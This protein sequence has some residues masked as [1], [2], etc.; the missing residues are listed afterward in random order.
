MGAVNITHSFDSIMPELIVLDDNKFLLVR[1]EENGSEFWWPPGA[2][3]IN[4]A[5]CNLNEYQPSQWISDTLAEQLDVHASSIE[6]LRVEFIAPDHRPVLVYKVEVKGSPKANE[7][8][9]FIEADYFER[10]ELPT[11]LGRDQEHGDW[12]RSLMADI[13]G[14]PYVN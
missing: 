14:S 2:Y 5:P 3:W 13:S 12:L 9:G 8:L 10:D 11:N 6:L 1:G 7:R 4:H